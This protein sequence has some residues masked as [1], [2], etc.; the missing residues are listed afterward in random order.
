M[1]NQLA[2]GTA[3]GGQP[4]TSNHLADQF[5]SDIFS[6]PYETPFL[7]FDLAKVAEAYGRLRLALPGGT[8]IKFAMKCNADARLLR[9]VKD[10]GGGFV[11]A[12]YGELALLR[13]LEIAEASEVLCSNPVKRPDDV[14]RA[15][16]AGLDRFAFDSEREAQKLAELAPG[17]R[18]YVRL[19]TQ[20]AQSAVASEGKF[21]VR[22]DHATRLM[23]YA[24]SLGL[25]PH[26]ITFHV[27]SQMTDPSAWEAAIAEAAAVM[28]ALADNGVRIQMLDLGGGFPVQYD[29]AEVPSISTIGTRIAQA[30]DRLPYPVQIV[31]EPGRFLAAPAGVMVASV[32]GVAERDGTRWVHLDV[33]AFNGFMES[34]ETGTAL[35]YPVTDSRGQGLTRASHLTG[36][37]CDSQDTIMHGVELSLDLDVGDAVALW[38][39]GA[40]T[41]VYAAEAFNGISA[42]SAYLLDRAA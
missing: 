10:L 36:P 30:V 24:A 14:A 34:L 9:A 5:G 37:T 1:R 33:G 21:G 25:I 40:Y 2:A 6:L 16:A 35:R 20:A 26:G 18:V 3:A 11:V 13:D 19:K 27:G 7:G 31:V 41:V 39:T 17:S 12:S 32:I 42:P 28:R 29:G 4:A 22:A 23:L 15:Y 8:E 38:Q